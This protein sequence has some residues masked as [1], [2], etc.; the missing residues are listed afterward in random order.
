MTCYLTDSRGLAVLKE[1]DPLHPGI[2]LMP[3]LAIFELFPKETVRTESLRPV[4]CIE[5]FKDSLLQ[6]ELFREDRVF[7]IKVKF[8]C[9]GPDLKAKKIVLIK[10]EEEPLM[11][12]PLKN[13]ALFEVPAKFI[14]SE[15]VQINIYG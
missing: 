3:P 7:I 9:S 11:T 4:W 5:K 8:S 2:K 1:L 10:E 15:K 12:V 14:N 6:V 13:T